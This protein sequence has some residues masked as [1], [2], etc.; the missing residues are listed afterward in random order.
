MAKVLRELPEQITGFVPFSDLIRS[1]SE[2][3][4]SDDTVEVDIPAFYD[5]TSKLLVFDEKL[6]ASLQN[7]LQTN[8]DLTTEL[9]KKKKIVSSLFNQTLSIV[10]K[11]EKS[12]DEKLTDLEARL[13]S[14]F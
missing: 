8:K 9:D 11:K 2:R 10:P 13:G 6:D 12:M 1:I 7:L 4:N 3:V 5:V 14:R